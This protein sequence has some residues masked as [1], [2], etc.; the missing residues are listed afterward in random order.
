VVAEVLGAG[1]SRAEFKTYTGLSVSVF[2][3]SATASG[4]APSYPPRVHVLG[5][6]AETGGD[7]HDH[8]RV[9]GAVVAQVKDDF[10]RVI[11]KGWPAKPNWRRC[12]W[13]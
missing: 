13:S 12:R 11:Q 9:S 7:Q 3:E 5:M 4:T 6:V 10:M 1:K 8:V 2:R